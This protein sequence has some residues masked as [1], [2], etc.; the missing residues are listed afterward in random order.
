MQLEILFLSKIVFLEA[1]LLRNE[2]SQLY[3]NLYA[4]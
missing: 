2:V 1:L 3:K 4:L